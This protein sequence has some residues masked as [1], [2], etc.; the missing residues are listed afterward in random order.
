MSG[1]KRIVRSPM[2]A[3]L[4]D[5]IDQLEGR[6][7]QQQKIIERLVG[8]VSLMPRPVANPDTVRRPSRTVLDPPD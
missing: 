5:R 8:I 4:E 6:I 2:E 1:K 3:L 7:D